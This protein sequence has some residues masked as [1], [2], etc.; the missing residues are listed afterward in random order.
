MNTA[1]DRT[2]RPWAS[3][4][5][6]SLDSALDPA[7]PVRPPGLADMLAEATWWEGCPRATDFDV[8]ARRGEYRRLALTAPGHVR[9]SALLVLWPAGYATPIHDH[10]G[11]WG[12]ECMLDGVLEVVSYALNEADCAH[13]VEHD[14]QLLGIGD[15][16]AFDGTGHAHQCR[17]T[18]LDRAAL[19]LHVYGGD[20]Q[21]F[22]IWHR[23]ETDDWITAVR[24]IP[25]EPALR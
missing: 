16:V 20:L 12:I 14:Q 22:R 25:R 18:S 24:R 8:P 17:N 19:S 21:R 9:Y 5:L 1:L 15:H 4:V 2:F 13:P 11:L 6:A 23:G 10:G 7:L 3:H